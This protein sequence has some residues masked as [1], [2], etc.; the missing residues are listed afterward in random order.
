MKLQLLK[1]ML[2]IIVDQ[3]ICLNQCALSVSTSCRTFLQTF[4]LMRNEYFSKC[5]QIDYE[6]FA[7]FYFF[8]ACLKYMVC[9]PKLAYGANCL[10]FRRLWFRIQ[11]YLAPSKKTSW[12]FFMC[13]SVLRI[14]WKQTSRARVHARYSAVAQSAPN[15]C[16]APKARTQYT[17][18]TWNLS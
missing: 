11:T 7:W 18:F 4:V 9:F 2:N 8:D 10:V 5:K 13:I 17:P 16:K 14:R 3:C 12:H 15:I 6:I 1:L